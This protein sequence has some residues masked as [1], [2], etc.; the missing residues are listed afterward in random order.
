[1]Q[2]MEKGHNSGTTSPTKKK[3]KKKKYGSAYFPSLFHIQNFKIQSLTV[4]DRVL[5]VTNGRT[6]GQTTQKQY[7]SSTSSELGYKKLRG[8]EYIYPLVCSSARSSH[9]FYLDYMI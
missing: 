1:M 5:S 6:N 2:E 8:G 3:K 7:G 4:L 9:F